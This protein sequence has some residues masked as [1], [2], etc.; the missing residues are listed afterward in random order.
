MPPVSVPSGTAEG[1]RRSVCSF[2]LRLKVRLPPGPVIASVMAL[3]VLCLAFPDHA[4]AQAVLT[5]AA[6]RAE[7]T[8]GVPHA[9]VRIN[10]PVADG[11]ARRRAAW[12][13]HQ[14][15]SIRIVDRT[16]IVR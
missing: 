2:G 14:T 5:F 4:R 3:V 16:A 6:K 13:R 1:L 15:I 8:L 11:L 12:V 9:Y 10:K 7:G